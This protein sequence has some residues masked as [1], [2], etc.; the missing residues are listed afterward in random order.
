[1]WSRL[2]L[3]FFYY[4][5]AYPPTNPLRPKYD[6]PYIQS[7][8][9]N[10]FAKTSTVFLKYLF[11]RK[12]FPSPLQLELAKVLKKY[13]E[14]YMAKSTG[15]SERQ[16]CCYKSWNLNSH[17]HLL[18]NQGAT[19]KHRAKQDW[20]YHLLSR[21]LSRRLLQQEFHRILC[22]QLHNLPGFTAW[23]TVEPL[24]ILTSRQ[25]PEHIIL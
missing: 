17:L 25:L 5:N 7:S 6:I 14:R 24:E 18:T 21:T 15:Y 23:P 13:G 3:F 4:P 1:M 9:K 8:K 22:N 2:L 11:L 19:V 20:M 16:I 10:N 12:F